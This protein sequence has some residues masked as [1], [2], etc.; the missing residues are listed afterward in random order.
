MRCSVVLYGKYNRDGTRRMT[1]RDV[2]REGGIAERE[3]FAVGRLDVALRLGAVGALIEDIPVG[4]RHDDFG[5]VVLLKKPRA[6][7]MVGMRMGDHGV[8]D[9]RRI[10]TQ[11]LHPAGNLLFDGVV[12][13]R[14]QDND[15]LGGGDGPHGVFRLTEKVKVIEDLHRFGIPS[16]SIRRALLAAPAAT[17]STRGSAS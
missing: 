13:D 7:V 11:L 5:A 9:I 2:E 17:R 8:F 10:E 6:T 12:E 15:A 1:G 14:V 4:R 3:F 16:G